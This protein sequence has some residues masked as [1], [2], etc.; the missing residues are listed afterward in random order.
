MASG[1][2][3]HKQTS[4]DRHCGEC[5]TLVNEALANVPVRFEKR[6]QDIRENEVLKHVT[7][8]EVLGWEAADHGWSKQIWPGLINMN[9]NEHQY[10]RAVRG[11]GD[12][13]P[14][15]FRVSTWEHSQRGLPGKD[16]EHKIEAER[17]FDLI[18]QEWTGRGW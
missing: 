13:A 4:D 11:Q 3:C 17:E 10:I 2:D 6:F 5:A 15:R 8:T 9:T 16:T 1:P 18:K 7:L 12:Y 14:H